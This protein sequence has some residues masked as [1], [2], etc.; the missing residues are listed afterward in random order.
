MA[1]HLD[2][3]AAP[4]ISGSVPSELNA[5]NP[6]TREG[7]ID[8]VSGRQ[9]GASGAAMAFFDVR[10]YP[11]AF[12]FWFERANDQMR[13]IAIIMG[14]AGAIGL[15]A[16]DWRIALIVIAGAFGTVP[17]VFAYQAI[18]GDPNRYFLPSFGLIAALAAASSAIAVARS[19]QDTRSLLVSIVLIGAAYLQWMEHHDSG[20]A[21]RNDGGGQG[22][23]DAVRRDIPDGSIVVAIWIDATPLEYA[24][25]VDG[26]L[27]TRLVVPGWPGEFKDRY[28]AWSRQKPV[29]IFADPH[30]MD[31]IRA[32]FDPKELRDRL[33]SDG[34][35][36]IVQIVTPG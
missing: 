27:G 2:P 22:T 21:S 35:H 15:L 34:Y 13:L 11:A 17:F 23:I 12:A 3:N 26:S 7:F 30:A 20:L 5:N 9:F 10:K 8:E 32:N 36:H 18:E 16:R 29:Y 4:P 28:A 25:F 6:S 19:R 14:A 1:H 31:N 33:S 24:E